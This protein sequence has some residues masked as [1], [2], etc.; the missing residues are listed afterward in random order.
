VR[1]ADPAEVDTQQTDL[2]KGPF[3]KTTHK[4]DVYIFTLIF[5]NFTNSHASVLSKLDNP[6]SLNMF[7]DK[8]FLP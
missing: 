8:T 6:N 2:K 4:S 1:T 5:I 3:L 7:P